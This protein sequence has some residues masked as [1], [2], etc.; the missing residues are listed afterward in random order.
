MFVFILMVFLLKIRLSSVLF[1]LLI[2]LK[3]A[4]VVT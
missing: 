1:T 4:E 3:N 2:L